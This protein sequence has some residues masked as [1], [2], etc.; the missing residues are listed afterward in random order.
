[1]K[2]ILITKSGF[3]KE[4]DVQY[5]PPPIYSMVIFSPIRVLRENTD[6]INP[7]QITFYRDEVKPGVQLTYTEK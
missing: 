3:T 2:A 5:P 7:E 4:L 6:I 1:M